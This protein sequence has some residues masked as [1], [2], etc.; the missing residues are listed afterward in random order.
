MW[1]LV[2][3]LLRGAAAASGTLDT[4]AHHETPAHGSRTEFD[5]GCLTVLP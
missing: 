5:N 1:C 3:L 2:I 4:H